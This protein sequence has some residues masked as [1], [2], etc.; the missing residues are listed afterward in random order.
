MRAKAKGQICIQFCLSDKVW[1]SSGLCTRERD[2]GRGID[3]VG[4]SSGIALN[5]VGL[6][7]KPLVLMLIRLEASWVI[8]SR[9]GGYLR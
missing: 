9:F 3:P 8:N 2:N 1:P 7:V 6:P 5:T 4:G